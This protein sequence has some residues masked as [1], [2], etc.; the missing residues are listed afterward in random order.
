MQV[1]LPP[2]GEGATSGVVAGIFVKVGDSV[3]KD[4]PLLELE[5]EKAVASIP[6][7]SAGTVAEILVKEGDEISVG[8]AIVTLSG[9]EEA[10]VPAEKTEHRAISVAPSGRLVQE[11][12]AEK[13]AEPAAEPPA[14]FPP[15]AAPS[16]RQFARSLGIDLRKV[17][18]S[19]HGGRIVLEDLRRY[20]A[21]LEAGAAQPPEST[22][23][24]APSAPSSPAIDFS[25]WGPVT[26]KKMSQLRLAISRKMTD[27]W[28]HVPHVTQ[29][30]HADITDLQ[31]LRK[32]YGP[33]YKKK[34]VSLTITP[35]LLKA[36]VDVLKK[37]PVFNASLDSGTNE[38]VFKNYYHFGIAVDTEQ[39]LLVPVLRDVDK[40]SMFEISGELEQLATR[41][42]ERKVNLDEMQGGTFTVSNQGGIAGGHFTPIINTP[43]VAILGVG[44]GSEQSV[45]RTQRAERRIML[46][47][48]LSYDHR[49]IDGADAAKFITALIARLDSF[50]ESELRLTQT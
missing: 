46:P 13:P 24:P 30:D 32:I 1:K 47:L 36:L 12:S 5:S 10:A 38:L 39:G 22:A 19:A 43:E 14:G 2:L 45:F 49:V 6:A 18:G 9:I 20:I 26:R 42:R 28:A 16:V 37:Y 34:N 29:F 15:P 31:R 33:I 7:P 17:A 27:S 44:R 23:A 41:A 35:F 21:R 11:P 50:R 40:K 4:Q 48:A 3:R 8:Q 25:R